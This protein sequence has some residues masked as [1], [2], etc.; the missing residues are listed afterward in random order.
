MYIYIYIFIY[1][2]ICISHINN[3]LSRAVGDAEARS[4]SEVLEVVTCTTPS[5]EKSKFSL[6]GEYDRKLLQ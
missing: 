4:G 1:R 5:Y 3:T 2:F 6:Q